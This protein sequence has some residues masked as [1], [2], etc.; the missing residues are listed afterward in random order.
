MYLYRF[1]LRPADVVPTTPTPTFAYR[2]AG[3]HLPRGLSDD[4][5]ADYY[6]MEAVTVHQD[7]ITEIWPNA[8]GIEKR[9]A[10]DEPPVDSNVWIHP[11]IAL[12]AGLLRIRFFAV[13]DGGDSRPLKYPP[14]HPVWQ[15]GSGMSY[16]VWVGYFDSPEQVLEYWP[17]AFCIDIIEQGVSEY[18][19]SDRF[20]KPDY[21][22]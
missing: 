12:K 21:L 9:F 2:F 5:T 10:L 13:G 6:V 15:S 11:V 14:P 17:D 3:E 1:N 22:D 19:Y 20:P 4:P 7:D 16:G 18:Q 8:F